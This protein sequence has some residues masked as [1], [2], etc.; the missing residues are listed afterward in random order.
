M[1]ETVAHLLTTGFEMELFQK[2][3]HEHDQVK[4]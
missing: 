1:A 3:Y 4:Y 2:H